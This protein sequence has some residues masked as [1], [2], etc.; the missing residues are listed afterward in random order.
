MTL[1]HQIVHNCSILLIIVWNMKLLKCTQVPFT[2]T[3]M[4][5]R[6]WTTM[7]VILYFFTTLLP[8]NLL[9]WLGLLLSDLLSSTCTSHFLGFWGNLMLHVLDATSCKYIFGWLW[10]GTKKNDLIADNILSLAYNL[11][12]L[13]IFIWQL[14]AKS[15]ESTMFRRN[16]GE[17]YRN[18]ITV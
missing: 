14:H 18:I 12:W 5:N 3:T 11:L 13:K 2:V 16:I 10:H 7:S 15:E 9:M 6:K 1:L 17:Q 8:I 4:N